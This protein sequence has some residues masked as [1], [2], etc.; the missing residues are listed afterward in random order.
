MRL[1]GF[2]ILG[3]AMLMALAAFPGQTQAAAFT[4]T[5]T[6]D[7]GDGTCDV[8]CSLREAII[9]ANSTPGADT[10]TVPAGTYKL[11]RIGY[12]DGSVK[13][14]LDISDDLV[15]I[16]AGASST[17][18]S[19]SG[20]IGLRERV[21]HILSGATVEIS[22]VTVQGGND[23]GFGGGIYNDGGTVTITNSTHSANALGGGIYND[24]GTMHNST[25]DNS[26][27][28]R[29]GGGIYSDGGTVTITNSTISDNSAGD[30]GGG[31][32]SRDSTLTITNSTIRDNSANNFGGGIFSRN[33][34]MTITYSTISG[35]SA[36]DGGG[37][38]SDGKVVTITNGTISGNSANKDGGGIWN[39]STLTLINS[40]I[41]G[42]SSNT[43]GGGIFSH[44]L[45][46]VTITN[47]IVGSN[48]TGGDCTGSITSGSHN[49]DSDGTCVTDGVN[50]DITADPLLDPLQNNGGPTLTHALLPG[51]PAIDAGHDAV[52]AA[53]PVNGV[54]QRGV[55]RPQGE[56]C[57]IGAYE[58]GITEACIL[59]LTLHYKVVNANDPAADGKLTMDF[60]IGTQEPATWDLWVVIPGTGV[61]SVWSLP[62]PVIDPSVSPSLSFP[63]PSMGA[64]GFLTALSTSEGIT[65]S[66]WATVDTGASSSAVPSISELRELLSGPSVALPNN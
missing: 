37:I 46:T 53:P 15:I 2:A 43:S 17:I 3:F 16:G 28:I 48:P 21:I 11:S 63:L 35:N 12:E 27:S 49:I 44:P 36:K 42:N 55:S 29:E 61:F 20:L 6:A 10:I 45:G 62:L 31:I 26:A 14:D 33:S 52:C 65:C 1:R 8:D 18:I 57:D 50:N 13:G 23:P 56:A 38:S 4:V 9:A 59:D 7:T 24:G 60:E 54:D 64:I 22:G 19:A 34:T 51:S 39:G 5:K 25:R 40:T 30:W 32:L 66:D 41:N 58:L 47:T